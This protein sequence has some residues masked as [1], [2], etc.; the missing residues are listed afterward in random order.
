MRQI[1]AEIF[2]LT[3][4]NKAKTKDLDN[5]N[6]KAPL[7]LRKIWVFPDL[8]GISPLIFQTQGNQLQR[9]KIKYLSGHPIH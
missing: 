8:N 1:L 3:A 4:L 6:E 9:A 2:R 5:I 7:I